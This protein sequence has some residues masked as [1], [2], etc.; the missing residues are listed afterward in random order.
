[1]HL[2]TVGSS[3]APGLALIGDAAHVVHPLAGQGVNL[4][5]ADACALAAALTAREPFR[6][7]GDSRLLR[8]YE[9]KRREHHVAL[10]WV[11][12]GLQRMFSSD[13]SL[14]RHLRNRGLELTDALPV[15]KNL[16][17]RQALG[18]F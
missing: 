9:R 10:Q 7:C 14:V 1:L 6:S 16:L 12:D 15:V 5:F 4:G 13:S 11:T 17:T 8:R 18:S 3:V 2:L